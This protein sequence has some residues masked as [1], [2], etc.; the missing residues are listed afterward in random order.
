[1]GVLACNRKGCDNIMCDRYSYAYGYICN[2]C[3]DELVNSGSMT[4]IDN[5]METVK[6]SG[7]PEEAL[8]RYNRVFEIQ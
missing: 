3:F 8:A 5:F 6:K 7:T 2:D 1:M 4:H